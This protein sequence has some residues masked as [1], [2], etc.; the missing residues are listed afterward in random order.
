MITS[1]SRIN[2]ISKIYFVFLILFSFAVNPF[3]KAQSE[4]LTNMDNPFGVLE[5]LH[6]NHSWNSYKYS[7]IADWDKVIK[8]MK[9]AGVGWVRMDFLW[10]DIEP[11]KGELTFEIYD[12]VVDL[13]HK[14]NI[15]ILGILDYSVEWAAACKKWNCPPKDNGLFVKYATRVILRYKDKIKHWEV[16]NEPD[17]GVYWLEQDGLKSYCAL[18]R[19]VYLA[20]KKTDPDCK[21]LNGGLASGLSSVNLL[22]DNGAKNYFDIL[23]IH[24]F[25][26]PLHG[27]GVI[28]AVTNYPKLA[29]KIMERNGDGKK[30]IWITEIGCPGVRPGVKAD[31]WWLGKNPSEKQQEEWVK[32]VYPELLKDKNVEKLFWAFFRDCSGHWGTG[33]DYFGLIRWDYS[34]KPGFKAYKECFKQWEKDK[35]SKLI[36]RKPICNKTPKNYNN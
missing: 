34:R 25:E 3:T 30:K 26:S 23:N 9:E 12:Q 21:I 29:H 14:N 11:K 4:E 36:S 10:E 17:S 5:F 32:K 19:D 6:W 2:R 13:L 1:I 15:H 27:A 24:F 31:N 8:L 33:V 20:A 16:W 18:L 7:S 28:K 22:Y 35:K